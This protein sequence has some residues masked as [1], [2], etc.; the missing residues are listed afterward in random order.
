MF[1]FNSS[2][3][4][5]LWKDVDYFLEWFSLLHGFNGALSIGR[6]NLGGYIASYI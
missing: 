5:V 2:E 3:S 6:N 4:E 1:V